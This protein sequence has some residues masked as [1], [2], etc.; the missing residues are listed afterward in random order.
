M[1]ETND[2]IVTKTGEP[3]YLE[4]EPVPPPAVGRGGAPGMP[5]DAPTGGDLRRAWMVA[6]AADLLQFGLLPLMGATGGF[7]VGL[8][9]LVAWLLIRWMGWHVAFLPAFVTELVPIA[10]VIPS[11]TLAMWVVT[12]LRRLKA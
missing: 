5:E 11:W 7:M 9:L 4:T 6:I 10:N 1:V 8:D 12:R 3:E 2:P